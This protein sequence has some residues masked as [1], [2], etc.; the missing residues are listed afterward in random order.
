MKFGCGM[1]KLVGYN[2][3]EVV[4]VDDDGITVNFGLNDN[5][6]GTTAGS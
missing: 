4:E 1:L 2:E 5:D 6:E 3:E